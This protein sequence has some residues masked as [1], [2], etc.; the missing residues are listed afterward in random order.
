MGKYD[1]YQMAAEGLR[2]RGFPKEADW[3]ELVMAVVELAERI[4]RRIMEDREL[5]KNG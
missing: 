5:E 4:A 1:K 2:R 3:P